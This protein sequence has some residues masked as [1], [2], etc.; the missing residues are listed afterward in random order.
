ME[1]MYCWQGQDS[2]AVKVTFKKIILLMPFNP[3]HHCSLYL[4]FETRQHFSAYLIGLTNM[5]VWVTLQWECWLTHWLFPLLFTF[6]NFLFLLVTRKQNKEALDWWAFHLFQH[7][8]CQDCWVGQK[9]A[10]RCFS[11]LL[12]SWVFISAQHPVTE[13]LV[14]RKHTV[15]AGQCGT[16]GCFLKKHARA[17]LPALRC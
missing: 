13:S 10:W 11:G 5:S 6:Y 1:G 3:W 15:C 14:F 16:R 7:F 8:D 12:I 4:L 17:S 2:K 9:T